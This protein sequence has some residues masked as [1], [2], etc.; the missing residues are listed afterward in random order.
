MRT[1]FFLLAFLIVSVLKADPDKSDYA[2][3]GF[4]PPFQGEIEIIGTFCEL[5]PNHFHGGLDIRTGGKIGRHVISVADGYVSRINIS[6][7]GYGN[8]LYITHPNGYTSV[9][10]HLH[11]FPE[12]IKCLI[13]CTHIKMMP[14][15]LI[16]RVWE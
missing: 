12:K 7:T 14:C 9:Y 16:L 6:T 4:G 5:R 11:D 13:R 3:L 10:G 8:A 15:R 2:S 1:A